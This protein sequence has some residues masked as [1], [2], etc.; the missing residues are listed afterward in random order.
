MNG[1][2][3][4]GRTEPIKLFQIFAFIIFCHNFTFYFYVS[5]CQRQNQKRPDA[6]MKGR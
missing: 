3:N 1:A 2:E 5:C 4:S 6:L